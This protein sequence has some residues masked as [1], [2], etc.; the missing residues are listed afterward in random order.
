MGASI[1]SGSKGIDIDLLTDQPTILVEDGVSS[2]TSW[3]LWWKYY[4]IFWHYAKRQ[5]NSELEIFLFCSFMRKK[6]FRKEGKRER[7][8]SFS[9]KPFFLLLLLFSFS[10]AAIGQNSF[11]LLL[12]QLLFFVG[13]FTDFVLSK[14]AQKREPINAKRLLLSVFVA[15]VQ[16]KYMQYSNGTGF[17]LI[18]IEFSEFQRPVYT[19]N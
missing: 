4:L 6:L 13:T 15:L 9:I 18:V 16:S 3:K 14:R 2:F 5:I 1:S 7:E 12:L 11:L 10:I 17:Y 19:I 8:R